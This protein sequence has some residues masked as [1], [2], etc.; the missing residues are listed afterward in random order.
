MWLRREAHP[1]AS[2][3]HPL[4]VAPARVHLC[5]EQISGGEQRRSGGVCIAARERGSGARANR[6]VCTRA[7]SYCIGRRCDAPG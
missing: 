7:T 3:A 2:R 1:A 5:T 4:S 6:A